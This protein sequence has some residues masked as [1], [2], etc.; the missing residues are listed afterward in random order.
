MPKGKDIRRE[1]EF[2]SSTVAR[3]QRLCPGED[4]AN[5]ISI[6]QLLAALS[7]ALRLLKSSNSCYLFICIYPGQLGSLRQTPPPPRSL[8]LPGSSA[9]SPG[10]WM[11]QSRSAGE[12]LTPGKWEELAAPE[13]SVALP[14]V[15]RGAVSCPWAEEK[16][17]SPGPRGL[18][19]LEEQKTN[20]R[21]S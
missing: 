17:I 15:R 3:E 14:V 4:K 12:T 2:F 13:L 9:A 7:E 10:H 5:L 16:Q 21:S 8:L 20:R 6:Q 19:F 18:W 1:G 11:C